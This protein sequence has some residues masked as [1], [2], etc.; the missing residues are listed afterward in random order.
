MNSLIYILKSREEFLVK[1]G[2]TSIN[3]NS[4]L[5]DYGERY[6]LE[7]FSIHK[8]Y[9]VRDDKRKSIEKK[10]HQKLIGSRFSGVPGARELFECTPERAENII[11]ETIKE[12]QPSFLIDLYKSDDLKNYEYTNSCWFIVSFL[13][14]A[15]VSI[16]DLCGDIKVYT[17]NG[18]RFWSHWPLF[19]DHNLYKI[20][21]FKEKL[22]INDK[23]TPNI[24]D[25]FNAS[26]LR[27]HKCFDNQCLIELRSTIEKKLLQLTKLKQDF[28]SILLDLDKE[29]KKNY[30]YSLKDISSI[31]ESNFFLKKQFDNELNRIQ[32]SEKKINELVPKGPN[33]QRE[34]ENQMREIDDRYVQLRNIEYNRTQS[35]IALPKDKEIH[36]E[37]KINKRIKTKKIRYTKFNLRRELRNLIITDQVFNEI[38]EKTNFSALCQEH[39]FLFIKSY[40]NECSKLNEHELDEILSQKVSINWTPFTNVL[41]ETY[42]VN[43]IDY[44]KIITDIVRNTPFKKFLDDTFEGYN[45]N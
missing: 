29:N 44:K 32:I 9:E 25:F 31:E 5:E 1:I 6:L 18:Y 11:E 23:S 12:L 27:K 41:R 8:V 19:D 10:V 37:I 3:A 7:G 34:K 35:Q 38:Q 22:V 14:L 20:K 24:S 43:N 39:K 42:F 16:Y 36:K 17:N 33:E 15:G 26:I 28:K 21:T 40:F 13:N 30:K 45:S 4:R 2:E